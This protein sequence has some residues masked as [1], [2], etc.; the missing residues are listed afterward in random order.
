MITLLVIYWITT[1]IYGAYWAVKNPSI[2]GFDD[3]EYFTLLEVITKIL[4]AMLI[5][6]LV[7]PMFLLHKI[8]FKR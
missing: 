7:V 5:A 4:P 1:T 6:W 2:R 3:D 8:K